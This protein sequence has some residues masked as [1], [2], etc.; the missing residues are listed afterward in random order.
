MRHD[1]LLSQREP[2]TP[3]H[4]QTPRRI[5]PLLGATVGVCGLAAISLGAGAARQEPGDIETT[6]AALEEWVEVKKAIS[7]EERDLALSRETL[8]SRIDIVQREIETTRAK[9]A[10]VQA[11]VDEAELKRAEFEAQG[12]KIGATKAELLS[13]VS[14]LETRTR[15]LLRK[16]PKPIIDKVKQLSQ[17]LPEDPTAS[18]QPVGERFLNVV[19]I[20]NEIN[21]FQHAI[22]QSS[23][24]IALPDGGEAEVTVMYLGIGQAWYVTGDG[25]KAGIGSPGAGGWSWRAANE[26]APVIA[27]ALAAFKGEKTAAFFALPVRVD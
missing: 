5:R 15:E 7:S 25:K 9:I 14:L 18:K 1:E 22:N 2:E 21:K 6:R 13:A 4:G 12:A 23:E 24:V 19:G 16:C 27:D 26:A 20:L 8:L 11:G 10:E 17:G 3:S